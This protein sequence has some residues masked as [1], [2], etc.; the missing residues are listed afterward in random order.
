MLREE[1]LRAPVNHH[2]RPQPF[3]VAFPPYDLGCI[4][5]QSFAPE[6]GNKVFDDHPIMSSKNSE[7]GKTDVINKLSRAR[8]HAT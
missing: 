8:V 7:R 6:S 3:S 1:H 5:P 4:A 2:D